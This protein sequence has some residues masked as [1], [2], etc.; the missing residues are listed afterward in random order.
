MKKDKVEVSGIGMPKSL[1]DYVKRIAK[2]KDLSISA[3]VTNI[4]KLHKDKD[5]DRIILNNLTIAQQN[6]I[7]DDTKLTVSKINRARR[8]LS[9]NET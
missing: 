1:W 8:F 5:I 4:V 6:S 7:S 9:K 3:T 2:G